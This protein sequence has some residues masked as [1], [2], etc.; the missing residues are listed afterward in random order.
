MEHLRRYGLE[1]KPPEDIRG[2]RVLG[3]RVIESDS[4]LVWK[5]DS[6][7]PEITEVVTKREC[8]SWA[9]RM[10]GHYPV[11]GWLRVACSFI[12]QYCSQTDWS[13]PVSDVCIAMMRH[14][15][16]RVLDNDPVGGLWSVPSSNNCEV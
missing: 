8:F 4:N 15:N 14:V 7:I 3:L 2:G 11:G 6:P 1:A 16:K 9:G 12:K 13:K 10:I 5:R